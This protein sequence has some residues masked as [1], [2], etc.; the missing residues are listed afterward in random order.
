MALI[1]FILI[2]CLIA[3]GGLWVATNGIEPAA[4]KSKRRGL[5]C[6]AQSKENVIKKR[7]RWKIRINATPRKKLNRSTVA[8]ENRT[9]RGTD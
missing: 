6:P 5:R 3:A 9:R 1:F 2:T 8:Q 7:H 4:D